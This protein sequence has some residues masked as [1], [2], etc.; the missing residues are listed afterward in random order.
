MYDLDTLVFSQG[1]SST[2]PPPENDWVY[3]EANTGTSGTPS[4]T[5][6][7]YNV[8]T[9]KTHQFKVNGS[10]KISID[11]D[12]DFEVGSTLEIS[13]TIALPTSLSAGGSG[14]APPTNPTAYFKVHYNGADRYIPYYT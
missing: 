2:T 11:D 1:A 8:P 13:N 6:M 12:I 3:I 10:L 4:L 5:G 9:N 7:T 14:M